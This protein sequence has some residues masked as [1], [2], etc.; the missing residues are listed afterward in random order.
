[1]ER[2]TRGPASH[3]ALVE[4]LGRRIAGGEL[5][6][7][8]TMTAR[9]LEREFGASRTVVREAV[10]VLEAHGLVTPRRRVGI[11]VQPREEWDNLDANVIGWVLAGPRRA[12]VLR[13]LTQLRTAVEPLAARLAATHAT[14]AERSELI[15]L[16]TALRDLGSAGRGDREE[17]LEVDIAYHSLLLRSS[18]N[19]LFARLVSPIAEIL[20]GRSALGLTP[21]VPRVGTL[22]AH[23]ATS[24]AIGRADPD[25][26]EASARTHL[27]LVSGEIDAV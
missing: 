12:D 4:E 1:M 6:P 5:P 8:A 24:E 16:A 22:E 17:Y 27:T 14:D 26:A 21:G 25:A 7:G 11:V 18:R 2:M 19:A 13:D 10:R 20:R 9:T 15:R 23:L 3:A